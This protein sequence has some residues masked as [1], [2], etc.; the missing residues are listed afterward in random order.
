[1]ATGTGKTL[2]SAGIIK[3]FLKTGNAKRVLF[4]VDRIELE[5]QA[6]KNFNEY[7]EKDFNYDEQLKLPRISK[8]TGDGGGGE[9]PPPIETIEIFDPD[10]LKELKDVVKPTKADTILDPA[11]G[12]AGFLISAYK[13]IQ[14]NSKRFK[15]TIKPARKNCFN[16]KYSRL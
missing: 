15:P 10:K 12:T 11:C 7:F 4:L 9:T 2:I 16:R 14:K 5:R 6:K 1:M 13:L 3:L 8:G